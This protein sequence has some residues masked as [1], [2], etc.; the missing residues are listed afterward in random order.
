MTRG[1]VA[2]TAGGAAVQWG[3]TEAWRASGA[4]ACTPHTTFIPTD[5][6]AGR[7][8]AVIFFGAASSAAAIFPEHPHV[9]DGIIVELKV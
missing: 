4:A 6:G 7:T 1:L 9:E 8:V 3:V 2:T 5:A